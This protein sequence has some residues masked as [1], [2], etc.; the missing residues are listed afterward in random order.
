MKKVEAQEIIDSIDTS[1][2]K[3]T[4]EDMTNILIKMRN[5]DNGKPI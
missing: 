5:D 2:E 3:L 1:S 4:D